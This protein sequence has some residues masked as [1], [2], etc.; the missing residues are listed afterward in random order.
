MFLDR[1]RNTNITENCVM[2][3]FDVTAL[4]TNVSNDSAMEAVFEMLNEHKGDINLYGFSV[5]QLMALLEACRS[6]TIFSWSGKHFAQIRGLAMGQRLAP[7]L[8]IAFMSRIEAPVLQCRPFLYCR[9]TDDCFVICATQA[10]MDKCFELMNGQN[11]HIKLTRD[12]PLDDWLP[13]LNAQINITNGICRTK[14]YRKP[15]NKN[16]LVHLCSAHPTHAKKAIVTNMFRTA[17]GVC[18]G[19][20]EKKES[21]ALAQRVDA[22]NGYSK[23]ISRSRKRKEVLPRG[24]DSTHAEKIAFCLPFISD[25]VSTAIRQCLRRA[26]LDKYVT[27]VEIPPNNFKRQ[28][29]RNRMYDRICSTPKCVVCP[30]GR[31]GDCMTSGVVYLICCKSCGEEYVAKRHVHYVHA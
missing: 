29:I 21:L 12:T 9:Y 1:L 24:R 11:E 23:Q 6:C 30:E 10:E 26:A 8:A 22:M 18:S 27:V 31:A 7:T 20:E 14:W 13:F 4:Y 17:A 5:S 3:S 28:L 19:I 2:E 25:E 16:I 15:S